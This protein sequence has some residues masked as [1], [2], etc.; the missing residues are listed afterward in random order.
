MFVALSLDPKTTNVGRFLK[1]NLPPI[2]RRNYFAAAVHFFPGVSVHGKRTGVT[3][4]GPEYYPQL[5]PYQLCDLRKV[6]EL[7]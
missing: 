2:V 4:R 5:R 6:A 3:V 1:V 7:P